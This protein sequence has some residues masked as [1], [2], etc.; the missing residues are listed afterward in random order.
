MTPP[1]PRNG[2]LSTFG[3]PLAG[4]ASPNDK[5]CPRDADHH[6]LG[7]LS[8]PRSWRSIGYED[9]SQLVGNYSVVAAILPLGGPGRSPRIGSAKNSHDDEG[10]WEEEA[11][12]SIRLYSV[13]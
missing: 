13:G 10:W 11:A 8:P 6:Y 7:N 3:Y 5:G 1:A 12:G 9:G 4:P 2:P